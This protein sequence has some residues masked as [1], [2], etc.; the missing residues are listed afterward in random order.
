MCMCYASH[1]VNMIIMFIL[2]KS[3]GNLLKGQLQRVQ[4]IEITGNLNDD[5]DQ[6]KLMVLMMFYHK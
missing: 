4:Q 2:N 1:D 5:Q 6:I 3:D